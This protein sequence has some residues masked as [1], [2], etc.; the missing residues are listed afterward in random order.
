MAEVP[1]YVILGRRAGLPDT[2]ETAMRRRIAGFPGHAPTDPAIAA[3]ADVDLTPFA[4]RDPGEGFDPPVAGRMVF[5][6]LMAAGFKDTGAC[7]GR[8]AGRQNDRA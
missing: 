1:A 7:R 6:G 8:L 4:A 3:A 5:S 2:T